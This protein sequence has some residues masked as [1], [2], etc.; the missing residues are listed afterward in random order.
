MQGYGRLLLD[1]GRK[2]LTG[3][4]FE[5]HGT[6]MKLGN[7]GVQGAETAVQP[8]QRPAESVDLAA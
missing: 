4:D 1:G 7:L 6:L 5:L 3:L 2:Q 8:L